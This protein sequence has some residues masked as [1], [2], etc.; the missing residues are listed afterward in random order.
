MKNQYLTRLLLLAWLVSFSPFWHC[1][2]LQPTNAQNYD[3]LVFSMEWSPDGTMLA[4]SGVS[5]VIV[6]DE[7]LNFVNQLT[8]DWVDDI[9]WRSDSQQLAGILPMAASSASIMIWN[10]QDP[11][12]TEVVRVIE[13]NPGIEDTLFLEWNPILLNYVAVTGYG[14]TIWDTTTGEKVTKIDLISDTTLSGPIA[15]SPQGDQLLINESA[16]GRAIWNANTG[17]DVHLIGQGV[18]VSALTWS[19]DGQTI[20]FD[21][22]SGDIHLWNLG[23]EQ[24]QILAGH[25]G[26]LT[27]LVWHNSILVSGSQD[28]TIRIWN[29]DSLQSISII[30]V[31]GSP[32]FAL[33]PDGQHLTY[34]SSQNQGQIQLTEL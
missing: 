6:Y 13:H 25:T 24:E 22:Q 19:P 27:G 15:W 3:G 31:G 32:K 34:F 9:T 28:G 30:E 10:L 21:A 20:A 14:T 29:V 11:E 26:R 23:N 5:G 7:N 1:L 16:A 33:H 4:V 12:I 8:T 2:V 17:L 18:S